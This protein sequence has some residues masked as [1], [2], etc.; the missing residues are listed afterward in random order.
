MKWIPYVLFLLCTAPTWAQKPDNFIR[1]PGGAYPFQLEDDTTVTWVQLADFYISPT[2]VSYAQ[3][4]AYAMDHG[5]NPETFHYTAWGE[6]VADRVAIH[7]NWFDAIRYANWLSEQQ[8][9][10]PAYHIYSRLRAEDGTDSWLELSS[11]DTAYWANETSEDPTPLYWDSLSWDR[12]SKGYRLPTEVEWEYAAS[13]YTKL[14]RV[15]VYAGTESEYSLD[16]FAWYSGNK[17]HAIAS[18]SPNALKLYDMSGNAWE[19]CFDVY[20]SNPAASWQSLENPSYENYESLR[21]SYR[22]LR[23][24]GWFNLFNYCQVRNRNYNHPG[25]RYIN[26]GFRLVRTL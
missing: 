11:S 15:Q 13:S 24:G 19:W 12:S 25:I 9:Y 1:I 2:E 26:D 14:G 17:A 10:S 21:T 6:P 3:M 20:A 5:I 4:A 18:R 8:G 23:G 22:C 7:V 16:D